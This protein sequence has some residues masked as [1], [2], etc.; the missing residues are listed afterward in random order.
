VAESNDPPVIFIV[1][2]DADVRSGLARL[3]RSFGLDARAHGSAAS[4]LDD[5]DGVARACVLIDITM[6]CMSGLQLMGRLRRCGST[7]P[8]IVV[9]ACDDEATRASARA[10]GASTFL[11][12]P[13]DERTLIDAIRSA[14]GCPAAA[15]YEE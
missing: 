12:K 13:V 10:L 4:F 15:Q 3:I 1:D 8:M 11:R 5:I 2:D 14:T 6:P 9:S 7:F